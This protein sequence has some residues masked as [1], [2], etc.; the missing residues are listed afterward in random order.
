MVR[1][2]SRDVSRF[3]VLTTPGLPIVGL[4]YGPLGLVCESISC[5]RNEQN[6]FYWTVS[7]EFRTGTEEQQQPDDQSPDPA[8][9]IPIWRQDGFATKEKI[10]TEDVNGVACTNSA[11]APFDQ[12]F[13]VTA[14]L[15]QYSFVQFDSA[16]LTEAVI[17]ARNDTVNAQTFRGFP[18]KTLLLHITS[19]EIGL[20]NGF[21]LRRIGYRVTY[22]PD[23]H[24]EK[25]LDVGPYFINGAGDKEPFMDDLKSFPIIGNLDGSG[26]NNGAT[27]S[28]I[29]FD[30]KRAKDFAS[31]LRT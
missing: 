28:T 11:G 10:I 15:P 26:G 6:V 5:E 9:W 16:D 7:A 4:L 19:N 24:V 23:T 30:V 8:N 18:A 21:Y 1:A 12:P 29:D 2:D 31:F 3:E 27:T 25:R 20:Y 14:Y 22:D 17:V 13:T